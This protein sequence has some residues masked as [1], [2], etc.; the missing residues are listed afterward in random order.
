[1]IAERFS[2]CQTT[3]GRIESDVRDCS[4]GPGILDMPPA[5]DPPAILPFHAERGELTC[6]G[7]GLAEVASEVGTPAYVYSAAA[8]RATYRAFDRALAPVPHVIHYAL[9][10]NS[11]LAVLRLLRGLGSG[12]DANS[13]GEIQVALRAG[14][15]PERLVFTGVGKTPEEL[16]RA[17]PLG[18]KSINAESP[19]ELERIDTLAR[20]L[21]TRARVSVR[22]N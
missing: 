19:G 6:D 14:F 9:K 20:S 16:R 22:L 13:W 5:A 4:K 11:T 3:V 17:V 8:I 2:G 21:G 7:V 12:A 10:A 15:I 1:M 18:L